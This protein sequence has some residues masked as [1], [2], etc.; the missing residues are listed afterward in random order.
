[1][2]VLGVFEYIRAEKKFPLLFQAQPV[3]IFKMTGYNRMIKS[4]CRSKAFKL[5]PG[6]QALKKQGHRAV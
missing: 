4:L 2:E 6:V 5:M 3:V 1:M